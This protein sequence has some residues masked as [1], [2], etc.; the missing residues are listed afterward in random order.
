MIN[1][2]EV[3]WCIVAGIGLSGI[4]PIQKK[5]FKTTYWSV[6]ILLL[7]MHFLLGGYRWAAYPLY[8]LTLLAVSA[9]TKPTGGKPLWVK[10]LRW[11]AAFVVPPLFGLLAWSFPVFSL[12]TPTGPMSVGA[13][14]H[15]FQDTSRLED[16]TAFP[17]D[18]RE[19]MVK[20]WYPAKVEQEAKAPYMDTFER[21]SMA[22][23]YGLP[24]WMLNQLDK[25]KTH[26]YQKPEVATGKHPMLLFAPGYYVP[27]TIYYAFIETLVSH[28]YVVV[29]INPT[30]ESTG[31]QFPDGE[32]LYY[33]D[34]FNTAMHS[35]EMGELTWKR[36]GEFMKAQTLDEK[37]AIAKPMVKHYVGSATAKR[38][39]NDFTFI[40]N[41]LEKLN[42]S[43]QSKYYRK[44]DF[45]KIGALGHS[46]GGAASGQALLQEPRLKAAINWDGTQWGDIVDSVFNKPF[47]ALQAYRPPE[48]FEPNPVIYHRKGEQAPFY[49]IR[50]H[51]AD[52]S[53]FMDIPYWIPL[54]IIS[55]AGTINQD[56]IVDITN[57]LTLA[58]FDQYL[59]GK[60]H[61]V[62]QVADRY[63]EV[64]LKKYP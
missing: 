3:S 43:P 57:Q 7:V 20:I 31:S 24:L 54:S 34:S 45:S 49:D 13:S 9:S 60:A 42:Q 21:N 63:T 46:L 58:F 29:N 19:L 36:Q 12:P 15:Y 41:Q 4:V 33:N 35:P 51:G 22:I 30:H 28:G 14:W 47:M 44:L 53:N 55:Q 10:G 6:L 40:L 52:H 1:I 17:G 2:I 62:D 11:L 16:I 56:R 25:V 50:V 26:T 23:K 5:H 64:V 38:W 39:A 48:V 32:H 37:L 61:N 8:G 18:Y 27:P 59:Q